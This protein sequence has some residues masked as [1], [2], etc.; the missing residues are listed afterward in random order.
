MAIQTFE[1]LI[2]QVNNML[3]NFSAE[4]GED[5]VSSNVWNA[6]DFTKATG[7][8]VNSPTSPMTSSTI[9]LNATGGAVR[10]GISAIWYQGAVLTKD[11]F[12]GGI[13][14]MFSGT[15]VLNEL[16]RVFIDVDTGSGAYSVNIQTGYTGDLPSGIDNVPPNQM[17]ITSLVE[18]VAPNQMTITD[19]T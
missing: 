1:E 9:A 16:C 4:V 10:G 3:Q 17:E 8:Y 12:T 7:A 2:E 13:V 18:D 14:T 19:I 5:V 11:S 15:N 6:V